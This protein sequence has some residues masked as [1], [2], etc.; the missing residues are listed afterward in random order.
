MQHSSRSKKSHPKLP[1]LRHIDYKSGETIW[2]ITDASK[3]G[4]GAV[5][6]QGPDWKTAQ[7]IA[8][9]SQ[10]YRGKEGTGEWNYTTH[11][12]EL[13]AITNALEKWSHYLLGV[14]F[15][16]C[17]DH[18][19]LKY[20]M[21]KSKISVAQARKA[22]KL[23]MYDFDIKHVRGL[24]NTVADAL[25]RD[26]RYTRT[27]IGNIDTPPKAD[28][29]AE[30]RKHA[31][32]DDD[33]REK[34]LQFDDS[35]YTVKHGLLYINNRVLIPKD[36]GLREQFL[37]QSHDII[38]HP[39]DH[40]SYSHLHNLC[41]WD[42]MKQDMTKYVKSCDTCQ[43]TKSRTTLKEG[44]LHSL[45]I[46][47]RP[48]QHIAMDWMTM[49]VRSMDP[50]TKTTYDSILV[51]TDRLSRLSVLIPT[52]TT[53]TK[54]ETAKHLIQR[55]F[56]RFG[57]PETI[58]SDRDPKLTTDY[59]NL[60]AKEIGFKATFSSAYHPQTDGSTE[61]VNRS[62]L[63]ILRAQ[64]DK[65]SASAWIQKL[66]ETEFAYNS[67]LHSSIGMSP[68]QATYGYIP[69]AGLIHPDQ[70]VTPITDRIDKLVTGSKRAHETQARAYNKRHK[71]ATQ[72]KI[73]DLVLLDTEPYRQNDAQKNISAKLENRWQ[74]P[75]SIRKVLPNDTYRLNLPP[76]STLHNSF[77][78]SRLKAYV[79]TPRG[80]YP[81]RDITPIRPQP[82]NDDLD[83]YEVENIT[84]HRFSSKNNRLSFFVLWKG[85]PASEGNWKR[86]DKEFYQTCREIID[87][88]TELQVPDEQRRILKAIRAI[89]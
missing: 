16:I 23:A 22:E 3:V 83:E 43:R 24:S 79:L 15:T 6:A 45:P 86:L 44:E 33:Y 62:I 67:R 47:T 38:G 25:S 81:D 19:S 41:A 2:L 49:K 87:G 65:K 77:H 88:Y 64:L 78:V 29:Y 71:P 37:K 60:V 54:E 61:R 51:I 53:T 10:S 1:S 28:I 32:L 46:P 8:F 80:E 56:S 70:Q 57:V 12:Q 26:N 84:R 74:G 27:M 58:V 40:R 39:D 34:E 11:D 13:L 72:Y 73:D 7:P 55:W 48:G 35:K 14:K 42:T 89:S 18:E 36:A 31:N 30:I 66:P 75:Y 52:T 68:F 5:L 17:T 59:W 21:T 69:D 50:I 9:E 4:I 85:Y 76:S 20:L 82:V 63:Q